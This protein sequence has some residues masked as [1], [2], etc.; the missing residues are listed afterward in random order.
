MNIYDENSL[1]AEEHGKRKLGAVA[2]NNRR[3]LK[4]IRNF[5]GAPPFPRA[6]SKRGFQ[7][8]NAL[9]DQKNVSL[10]RRPITRKFA[11]TLKSQ[12]AFSK[13]NRPP[14]AGDNFVD[15]YVDGCD[16]ESMIE[17][18]LEELK[19]PNVDEELKEIE[20][21]DIFAEKQVVDIDI[22]DAENPLAVVDYVRDIYDFYKESEAS[23]GVSPNYM[24]NQAD[25]NEKM[26][27]ILI[28][29]LIEVHH[30]FDLLDETLFLMVNIIDR[31][32]AKQSVVRKKLQLV[33]VTAMLL[34]CKYEEVSVPV[35][36]DLVVICDRAYSRSEIL[37]ME[38]LMANTLQFNMSVP[39]S[40]VFMRRFLKAAESDKE[41]PLS[42]PL[43]ALFDGSALGQRPLN[44]TPVTQKSNFWSVLEG[45]WASMKRQGQGSSREF[46]GNL[47]PA[48]LGML[49]DLNQLCS[50]W[51][52]NSH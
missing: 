43:G 29:W 16:S 3:A 45:W 4:D 12:A 10:S 31:F 46:I 25:I 18:R 11:A 14:A 21:E 8:E 34:A 13:E 30:K 52:D 44:F 42:I 40:Y 39:T 35:V 38:R 17:E 23:S 6:V 36:E 48:N 1:G 51:A 22:A 9:V 7:D 26:R 5:M 28:D 50:C 32:L 47:T 20:M 24:A 33:G 19:M 37:D 27:A 15:V 49:Q 2:L 41:R